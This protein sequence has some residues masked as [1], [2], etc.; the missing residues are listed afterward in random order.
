[1]QP[2]SDRSAGGAVVLCSLGLVPFVSS[3][4]HDH[5]PLT[6]ARVW[7]IDLVGVRI[8]RRLSRRRRVQN[9]ARLNASSLGNAAVSNADRLRLLLLYLNR[10]VQGG[11]DWKSWWREVA[12]VTRA[13]VARNL[14]NGRPLA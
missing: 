4:H 3:A 6:D 10:A 11:G 9:L 8:H 14:Q 7:F 12:R 2:F 5:W 13:K 1:M